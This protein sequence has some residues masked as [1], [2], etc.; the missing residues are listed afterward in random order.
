[1]ATIANKRCG[2]RGPSTKKVAD[3]IRELVSICARVRDV[4]CL[5]GRVQLDLL[6]IPG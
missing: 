5:P 4:N 1:M 2:K 3:L 6:V